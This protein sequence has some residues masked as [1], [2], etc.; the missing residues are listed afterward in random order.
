MSS[1]PLTAAAVL[2][3][4][5][6]DQEHERR[7]QLAA[8][9]ED[10]W[11]RGEPLWSIAARLGMTPALVMAWVGY[12]NLADRHPTTR[13]PLAPLPSDLTSH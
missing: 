2:D 9:I 6:H 4:Q 5:E 12:L 3:D 13:Q 1:A 7:R 11:F 8:S 10:G